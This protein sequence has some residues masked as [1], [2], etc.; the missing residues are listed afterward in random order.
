MAKKPTARKISFKKGETYEDFIFDELNVYAGI[1]NIATL[2]LLR[3][4]FPSLIAKPK[5]K[6][7]CANEV[8]EGNAPDI[9]TELLEVKTLAL[10]FTCDLKIT[11]MHYDVEANHLMSE[12]MKKD[13]KDTKA[14][15][16]RAAG[17][18]VPLSG[19]AFYN[20]L[21]RTKGYRSVVKTKNGD[22]ATSGEALEELSK[23]YEDDADLLL[24][25][26]R[27]VDVRSM[28]NGFIDGYIAKFVKYDH[29]IHCDY[30]LHGTS[31][32]RMSSQNPNML[33]MS[34]GYYGYNTR[35]NYTATPGYSLI[36]FD[37]S[38]C[39]V[40]IL[41]ALSGDENMIL[42]CERG[43][44]FHSFSASMMMDIPY[45]DFLEKKHI[46]EYKLQ[47]QFAKSV[48]FNLTGGF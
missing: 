44:D 13:M 1:D 14:R 9:L 43:Y 31:S 8:I 46:K 41:A 30:L 45:E 7:V 35:N 28:F 2:D 4:L 48:T 17:M 20:Y 12:R 10:E 18:D 27:F 36:A 5:Y 22:E 15:I 19:G 21:Y 24:D 16:D 11:G 40:K 26:K 32:H 38:S 34:R 3:A 33:N 6:D 47:R 23:L 29:R 39:E 25:I 37:F 42:A